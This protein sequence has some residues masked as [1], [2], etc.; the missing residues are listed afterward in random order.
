MFRLSPLLVLLIACAA[1]ALRVPCSGSRRDALAAAAALTLPLAASPAS[2]RSKKTV[3][4]SKQ[5]KTLT[6]RSATVVDLRAF[7]RLGPCPDSSHAPP[8]TLDV[9]TPPPRVTSQEGLGLDPEYRKKVRLEQQVANVGMKGSRGTV[10]DKDF[11]NLEKTR[12]PRAS[13]VT[14]SSRN[15]RPEDLGLK[16]WDGK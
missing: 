6:P 11:D 13:S 2:A 4:P 10:Y 1:S 14:S 15:R 9:S 16:Q 12:V 3:N 7:V 8:S 5:A